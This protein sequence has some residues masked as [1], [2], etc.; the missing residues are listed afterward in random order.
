ML[1]YK[2]VSIFSFEMGLTDSLRK[3]QQFKELDWRG[4]LKTCDIFLEQ[5]GKA[6]GLLLE[7]YGKN[8]WHIIWIVLQDWTVW[9]I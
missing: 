7:Q 6:R 1:W 4:L 3:V 8:M 9:R 5:S 2:L